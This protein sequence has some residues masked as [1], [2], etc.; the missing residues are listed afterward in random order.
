MSHVPYA[1]TVG[2]FMYGMICTRSDIAHV[3]SVVSRYMANP[4][5]VRWQVAKQI[6]HY[7]KGTIDVLVYGNFKDVKSEITGYVDSDYTGDL[8]K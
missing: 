8:D 1:S 6:F 2:S 3:V 7:L 4:K 5:K